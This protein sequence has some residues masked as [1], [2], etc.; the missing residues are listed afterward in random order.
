MNGATISVDPPAL[1]PDAALLAADALAPDHRSLDWNRLAQL[2]RQADGVTENLRH[3]LD[4]GS[5]ALVQRFLEREDT[6]VLVRE[7][8]RLVDLVVVAAWEHFCATAL[9]NAALIAVGGYG[10]GELHPGSDVDLLVLL[11]DHNAIQIEEPVSAFVAR[12]WD[13]GL[14]L[15][16]SVRNVEQCLHEGREDIGVVTTLMEARRLAGPAAL[17]ES[18]QRAIGPDQIWP[19]RNFFEAKL[20]EQQAR[21]ARYGDTAYTLEPNIK[22]GPGCL[23]DLQV[24]SWISQRH[25][26][27]GHL[28]TLVEQGFLT[29]VQL[30]LLEQGREFLWQLRFA[31]HVLTGRREDR[32]LFDHQIQI[33]SL[34]DYEDGAYML[35]V[36]Q[37]MQRFYRTVM[38]LSR[39]NEMVLQLFQEAI[40]LNPHAEPMP[41]N[42]RFQVRNGFLQVT[43][44]QVFRKHPSA[45]LEAFLLLQQHPEIKG[46]NARTITAIKRDL[47]L[48]D[49]A[50]RQDPRN[51]K[52]F[53]EI[54]RAPEGVTHEL[55]RMN[56]Y[57]VLGRYIPAF[58]RIVGRMQ[59]DLFHTYT[60]DA[61]TLFVVSNLRRFALPRF[62]HEFPVCS[63]IMQ[64]LPSPELAYM[65]GLFHDIAKGRGGDHSEL[66]AIEAETFCLEHGMSRYDARLVAWL[67]RHH[68]LLS[69]TAQK[70]DISDPDVIREF[71]EIVGDETH[72][73]YLYVLTVADVRATNPNLWNS[74]RDQLFQELRAL[75]RQALRRGLESPIDKDELI[76]ERKQAARML[77]RTRGLDDGTIDLIWTRFSDD[78]FLRCRRDEIVDHSLLLAD[79]G[80]QSRSVL[81]DVREQSRSGGT[82]VFLFT[83]QEQFTFAIATAVLDE[84]GLNIADARIIALPED[85][86][87][88][89][90]VILEANGELISDPGRI[91]QIRRRLEQAME[92]GSDTP[93]PVTRRAPRQFRMFPTQPWIGFATDRKNRHTV[94]EVTAGDRPGLLCEI[95]KL[96]RDRCIKIQTAKIMTVGERAEDVFYVTDESGGPLTDEAC[97]ELREALSNALA[98][99]LETA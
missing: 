96:M 57:G 11:D 61:H 97:S 32:L 5:C 87:L 20:K 69:L 76:A 75:A 88:A 81:I 43:D 14:E 63:E 99:N 8:A 2:A 93:P 59:Y 46:V 79:P 35:A 6:G 65:A 78:Y 3:V 18:M 28:Q 16:H 48:I 44:D 13:L 90:F 64:S 9:P 83:P 34:L 98:P 4:S 67:V 36:E 26:G 33:A 41:L 27:S 7:R 38:D 50:F 66:G 95:G 19:S 74:W 25:F 56:L 12:L 73:D 54:L 40:L 85:R 52:L 80:N 23:R 72:L 53:M 51:Q 60:V 30:G 62:N 29:Q 22:N 31:L 49:D 84:L 21:H 42:A 45:L 82:A 10:R 68:L 37:L 86:S 91:Q 77:L 39:L 24:I 71:A 55:R 17:F 70:K 15:G 58:G 47:D 92:T 1:K 94:I 89:T